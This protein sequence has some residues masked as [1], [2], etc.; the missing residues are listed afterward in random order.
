MTEDNSLWVA[1]ENLFNSHC[2]WR[3]AGII[4]PIAGLELTWAR[5]NRPLADLD[6]DRLD[7]WFEI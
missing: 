7:K 6:L 1:K 4:Y 5:Y 2:T 3:Y